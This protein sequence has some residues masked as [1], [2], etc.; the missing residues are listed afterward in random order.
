PNT[1]LSNSDGFSALT[2]HVT[3]APDRP[4]ARCRPRA[5]SSFPAPVGPRINT[6]SRLGPMRAILSRSR[7]ITAE[8]PDDEFL[9]LAFDHGCSVC[10]RLMS[11]AVTLSA[12]ASV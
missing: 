5:T 8:L 9:Q 4:L 11:G 2:L 6:G 1:A 3:K 12:S 10:A 7:R